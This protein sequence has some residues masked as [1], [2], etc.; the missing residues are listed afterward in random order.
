[1]V[2]IGLLPSGEVA[3]AETRNAKLQKAWLFKF[4]TNCV[5]IACQN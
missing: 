3:N 2:T 4:E 5:K 1:M